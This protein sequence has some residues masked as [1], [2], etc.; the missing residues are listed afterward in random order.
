MKLSKNNQKIVD[1]LRDKKL[2]YLIK[3]F[4][5]MIEL[6]NLKEIQ[7]HKMTWKVIMREIYNEENTKLDIEKLMIG[8]F[9]HFGVMTPKKKIIDTRESKNRVAKHR[10]DKKALGY[11]T[12]SVQLDPYDFEILKKFRED[13]D[14][15]YSEA[16]HQ[17][18]SKAPKRRK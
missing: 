4:H 8:Y 16:I 18:L 12:I 7:I 9:V 14:L 10:A 5:K 17:L 11:K 13:F 15:T 2:I 3:P 1:T 6:E